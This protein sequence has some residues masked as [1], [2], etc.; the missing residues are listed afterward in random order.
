M[1]SWQAARQAAIGRHAL[2]YDANEVAQY[3]AIR[4]LGVLDREDQDVYLAD[5]LAIGGVEAVL[6]AGHRVLDVGAGT[7]VMTKLFQRLPGLELHALEPS[8]GMYDALVRDPELQ[9]VACRLGGCDQASDC[10]TYAENSFHAIGARQVCNGLWDPLCA[11]R[12]WHR[13]LRPKGVMIVIEGTYGRDG[14]RGAWGEEVDV[15]PLASTQSL[16]TLPY[17]LEQV[18]FN[19][20]HV[21]W[22]HATNRLEITKTPRYLVVARKPEG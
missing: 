8:Q 9:S 14:W 15:L 17:L 10:D 12:H 22:M 21:D 18:G 4:G 16:A 1:N 5:M 11:F 3:R 20:E 7:G 2:R 19:V 13:W 6:C